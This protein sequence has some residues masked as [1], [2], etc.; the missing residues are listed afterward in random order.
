MILTA[1]I[2]IPV[3]YNRHAWVD[4]LSIVRLPRK[5]EIKV[6]FNEEEGAEPFNSV[7]DLLF[8]LPK[9]DSVSPAFLFAEHET[10]LRIR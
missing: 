10:I 2:S 8:E 3:N 9:L 5:A 6:A 4:L 7:V 1:I